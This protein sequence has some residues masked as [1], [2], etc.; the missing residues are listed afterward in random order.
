MTNVYNLLLI[1]AVR[2]L[3]SYII[4]SVFVFLVSIILDSGDVH[5]QEHIKAM[6]S[7]VSIMQLVHARSGG[8][9]G[10][11]VRIASGIANIAKQISSKRRHDAV[12]TR[13]TQVS[14][15]GALR[16]LHGGLR[17][18]ARNR[19]K[20]QPDT[21]TGPVCRTSSIIAMSESL[22]TAP[23][24]A[25]ADLLLPPCRT[26]EPRCRSHTYD[27]SSRAGV[28]AASTN[29]DIIWEDFISDSLI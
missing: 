8:E 15:E 28:D 4:E 11:M 2:L 24:V 3:P 22:E 29:V 13:I 27:W 16:E 7:A 25:A 17:P 12:S 20:V 18:R 6:D 19:K 21:V 10:Q 23:V 14:L 9:F 1:F 26:T 5:T